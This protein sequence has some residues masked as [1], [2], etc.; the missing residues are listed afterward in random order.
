MVFYLS[1]NSNGMGHLVRATNSLKGLVYA[2]MLDGSEVESV[3][4]QVVCER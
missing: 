3:H 1:V 4:F 2:Y